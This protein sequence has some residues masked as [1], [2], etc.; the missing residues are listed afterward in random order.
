MSDTRAQNADTAAISDEAEDD[1]Q[2]PSLG[3][4]VGFSR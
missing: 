2:R 1:A 4:I 3:G